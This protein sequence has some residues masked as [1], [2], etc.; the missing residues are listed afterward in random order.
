ML[1][2]LLFEQAKTYIL[3]ISGGVDSVALLH[4]IHQSHTLKQCNFVVAHVQHGMREDDHKDAALVRSYAKAYKY[5]YESTKLGE[6]R[7]SEAKARVA[8]YKFFKAVQD[9]Y[10]ATAIVTA[11]HQNDVLETMLINLIRGTN[12]R[13]LASLKSTRHRVRPLLGMRKSELISY[14]ERHNL[15]WINDVTNRDTRYLRNWVRIH[16]MPKLD[17][18]QESQLLQINEQIAGINQEIDQLVSQIVAHCTN[19]DGDF[20]MRQTD[21]ILLNRSIAFELLREVLGSRGAEY[22]EARIQ[23]M[24]LQAKTL[25]H[26]KQA[27]INR[28]LRLSVKNDKI[29]IK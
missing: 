28:G 23:Y 29:I 7:K 2:T 18:R 4:M 8:R 9:K 6:G 17:Q 26:G 21:F 19:Q 13:G 27:S 25:K 10:G 15:T 16:V 1:D 12:R 20:S 24:W 22:T 3:A 11:H 5:P 14:A